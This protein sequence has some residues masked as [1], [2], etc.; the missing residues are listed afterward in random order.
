MVI[1]KNYNIRVKLQCT[2]R[3]NWSGSCIQAW[4]SSGWVT[5][6]Q[7][8]I[9]SNGFFFYNRSNRSILYPPLIHNRIHNLK[10]EK[11]N[12]KNKRD[13]ICESGQ[14]LV[15][16][17]LKLRRWPYALHKTLIET[18]AAVVT[19]TT[20]ALPAA[21]TTGHRRYVYTSDRPY[22]SSVHSTTTCVST[23]RRTR[24]NAHHRREGPSVNADTAFPVYTKS[25]KRITNKNTIHEEHIPAS[26]CCPWS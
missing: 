11:K 23:D 20:I 26:H 13:D 19:T 6:S 18:K 9:L 3:S 12:N 1:K 14:C 24:S 17:P 21:A 22:A 7:E 5:L 16:N 8:I 10:N 25:Q 15:S 2:N 4:Y